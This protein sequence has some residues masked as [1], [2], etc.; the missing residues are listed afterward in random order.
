MDRHDHDET[1]GDRTESRSLNRATDWQQA[2]E[3]ALPGLRAFLRGRLSQESD[4]EDCLQAVGVAMLE[5]GDSVTPVAMRSW[6]FRVAANESA[7]IWRCRAS[8]DKALRNYNRPEKESIEPI[9]SS[10]REES[11]EAVRRAVGR[12]PEP[13]R[14]VVQLR[15]HED[16]TFQQIADQLEIPLGTALSQMRRALEQLRREMSD[17]TDRTDQAR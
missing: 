3:Q 1:S 17:E 14:R 10:L 6:L 12:L 8:Q 13:W 5:K 11:A 4:I 9:Q 2:F 15:I 16:L 7:R